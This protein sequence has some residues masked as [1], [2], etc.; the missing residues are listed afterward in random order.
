[1]KEKQKYKREKITMDTPDG[2]KTKARD[3]GVSRWDIN[4]LVALSLINL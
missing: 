2:L 4:K 1:M 3:T